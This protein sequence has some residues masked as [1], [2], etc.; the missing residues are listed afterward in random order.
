LTPQIYQNIQKLTY[1]E[2][3]DTISKLKQ[4]VYSGDKPPEFYGEWEYYKALV[5]EL[6]NRDII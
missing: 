6:D 1:K 4:V 3:I 2:L 5:Q